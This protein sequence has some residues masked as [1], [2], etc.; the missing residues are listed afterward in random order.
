SVLGAYTWSRSIDDAADPFGFTGDSGAAQNNFD[1]RQERARS[2]FDIAHQITVG[3][4]YEIPLNGSEWVKGWQVNGAMTYRTGQPFTP[5][6]GFD[7]SLT[8]S[9]FTRPNYAPGVFKNKDGQIQLDRSGPVDPFT[10]LPAAVV[11]ATGQFGTLGR[12][13]FTGQRY[14]NVDLSVVKSTRFGERLNLQTR[15]EIFNLF[16]TTNLA[17][18][19]RTLTDPLF[20]LSSKTQDVAGGVPGIGGG[21]PRTIQIALRLTY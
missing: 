10:G 12:N 13:T 17:L 2:V 14:K 15:F 1:I 11:P 4:T 7:S 8:G 16:N 20:G 3:A 19:E 18:P 6:L 9:F 21:G 5:L